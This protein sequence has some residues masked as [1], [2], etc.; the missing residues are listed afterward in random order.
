MILRAISSRLSLFFFF[1]KLI[2]T[3]RRI[4]SQWIITSLQQKM[5]NQAF[6]GP[7][8]EG[9]SIFVTTSTSSNVAV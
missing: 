8:P 7:G 3:A 9:G 2:P 4:C 1:I 6:A 5:T